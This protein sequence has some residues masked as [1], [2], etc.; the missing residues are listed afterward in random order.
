[1]EEMTRWKL[2]NAKFVIYVTEKIS[3]FDVDE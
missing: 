2:L 1:M 3:K